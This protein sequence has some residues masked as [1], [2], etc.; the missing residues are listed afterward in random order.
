[1][2]TIEIPDGS[3]ELREKPDIKVRHR[4]L[5]EAAGVAAMP[6]LAKLPSTRDELENL[7]VAKVGSLTRTEADSLFTLQDATII[8]ALA[9]WT[10]PKP[11]PTMDTVGDLDPELYDALANATRELGTSVAT[12]VD[13]DPPDPRSEGFA[14]SP[15]Q[16]ST[17]SDGDLR[18]NQ[19]SEST[20]TLPTDTPSTAT[21]E[22]SV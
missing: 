8:A 3:A 10:L 4:R 22:S 12:G 21:V 13:F 16:P 6:G 1:M 9:S 15:T 7:D 11:L 17:A 2:K 14:S 19:G 18:A 5:I 20:E